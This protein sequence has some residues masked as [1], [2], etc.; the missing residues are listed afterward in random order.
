M[1]NTTLAGLVDVPSDELLLVGNV[2]RCVG[3][4]REA[5]LFIEAMFD[6]EYLKPALMSLEL[7][8]LRPDAD[9]LMSAKEAAYRMFQRLQRLQ[10]EPV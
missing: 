5:N 9:D 2:M 10:P 1:K 7:L 4:D 6:R 3:Y 8:A